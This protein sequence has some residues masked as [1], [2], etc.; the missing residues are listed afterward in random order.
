MGWNNFLFHNYFKNQ[1]HI[2]V[3]YVVQHFSHF[4]NEKSLLAIDKNTLDNQS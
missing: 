2:D 1:N 3:V 4:L